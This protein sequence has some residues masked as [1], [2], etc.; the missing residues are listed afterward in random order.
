MIH[1]LKIYWRLVKINIV[2]LLTYR[3]NFFNKVISTVAWGFF[4][5]AWI[6]LLTYKTPSV[7]GWSH[8]ELIALAGSY[9]I[10][11]AIV[12][13]LFSRNFSEFSRIVNYG[14]FDEYLIKPVDSQFLLSFKIIDFAGL[15]RIILGFYFVYSILLKNHIALTFANVAGYF[16]LM[17]CGLIMTY[18]IWSIFSTVII[19]YPQLNNIIDFLFNFNG[20][21]R[22]PKEM[23]LNTRNYLLY[24]LLPFTLILSTPTK[25]LFNKAL[26]GDV[27]L[28]LLFTLV[29]IFVAR[30]FWKFALRFY[31]SAS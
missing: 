22:Y 11:A 31:T 7:F 5:I 24:F 25:V 13:L 27:E 30:R 9:V 8:D 15:F 4:Q 17:L 26:S 19:W 1:Y 2:Y 10:F 16:I 29:F 3:F 20:M 23:I 21:S 18:G 12:H 14:Q 28:L 6:E